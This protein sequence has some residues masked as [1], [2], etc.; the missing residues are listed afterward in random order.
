M[1]L[2]ALVEAEI[3][4]VA[5]ANQLNG[6]KETV[7]SFAKVKLVPNDH[8]APTIGQEDNGLIQ[9]GRFFDMFSFKDK[10]ISKLHSASL[11]RQQE[12]LLEKIEVFDHT[13]QSLRELLREWRE[14]EVRK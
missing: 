13:N 11:G 9:D 6:L 10:R 4:G 3:D 7:D 5:V 1:L 8:F 14:Y 12:L 2:R